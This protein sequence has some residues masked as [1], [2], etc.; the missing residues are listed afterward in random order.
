VERHK[1]AAAPAQEEAVVEVVEWVAEPE[2]AA[3][4]DSSD[5]SVEELEIEELEVEEPAVEVA[6]AVDSRVVAA[7]QT[8]V[9]A[10]Q[11]VT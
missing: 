6:E 5:G 9:R 4:S 11:M 7:A 1:S 10:L 8:A 3:G 2:Q